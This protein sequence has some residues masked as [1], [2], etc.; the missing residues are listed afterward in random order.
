VGPAEL[1]QETYLPESDT[2]ELAKV[3][4]FLIA[5]ET[6]GRGEIAPRFLLAG[7]GS[8]EQVEIPAEVY[9][10]LRQVIEAMSR[11]LAVTVVPHAQTL[12]TQQAAELLGVSRPTLIRLLEKGQIPFEK[13]GSHRR[14]L[15]PDVLAYRDE[16]REQ[17]YQAL[18]ATSID[19]DEEQDIDAVLASLREARHKVASQRRSS[20]LPQF[21]ARFS[22]FPGRREP[23]P[24][25]LE[26]GHTRGA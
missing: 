26:L 19:I 17:Q 6:A 25:H 1:R 18:E 5:Y 23:I 24:P 21:T 14:L 13:A 16:R 22:P 15:L 10:V 4:D 7:P 20:S 9:G 11:G 3:H 2:R 8:G 12:T